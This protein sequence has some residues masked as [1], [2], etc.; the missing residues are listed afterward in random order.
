MP[1]FIKRKLLDQNEAATVQDLCTVARRQMVFFELCPSDDWSRDAFNEVSS[2]LS[3][4]LVGAL[5]KVAQQ[6]DELKQQQTDLSNRISSLNVPQITNQN[7][8]RNNQQNYYRGNNR[9][10][11]QREFRGRGNFNNR[12]RGR[13]NNN[14]GYYGINYNRFSNPQIQESSNNRHIA[15]TS[16]SN[17]YAILV[18]TQTITPEIAIRENQQIEINKS[19]TKQHQKTN[20]ATPL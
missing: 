18:D 10:N 12:G 11:N 15:Q 19:L 8:P 2:S 9:F 4:N 6:Q 14:R 20:K 13:F 3:E 5:T 16:Y 1:N 17:K 7:Y